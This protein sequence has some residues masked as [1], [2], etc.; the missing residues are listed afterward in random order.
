MVILPVFARVVCFICFVYG[1]Y[2]IWMDCVNVEEWLDIAFS[3]SSY[4]AWRYQYLF[5]IYAVPVLTPLL[6]FC[7]VYIS[8]EGT[9]NERYFNKKR[10]YIKTGVDGPC[11][12]S[13]YMRTRHRYC[14]SLEMEGK[15]MVIRDKVTGLINGDLELKGVGRRL[16]N[17]MVKF[18][19]NVNQITAMWISR[20]LLVLRFCWGTTY[21]ESWDVIFDR[22]K[23]IEGNDR[24]FIRFLKKNIRRKYLTYDPVEFEQFKNDV[25]LANASTNLWYPFQQ[26]R[27][28]IYHNF[29]GPFK[30]REHKANDKETEK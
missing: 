20:D 14:S 6:L 22:S 29:W 9:F 5:N 28:K 25:R 8:R 21:N 16:K 18:K 27:V 15:E 19:L 7:L 23:F 3:Y 24:D 2:C 11:C 26:K 12:C 30:K 4:S 10:K 17:E 13:I 1:I